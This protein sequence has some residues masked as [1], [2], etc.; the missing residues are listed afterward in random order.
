MVAAPFVSVFDY[1]SVRRAIDAALT[2]DDLSD[3]LIGDPIYLHGAAEDVLAVDPLAATRSGEDET[4]IKRA[5]I[6]FLAAR[7]APVVARVKQERYTDFAVQYDMIDV[8]E[9]ARQLRAEALAVLDGLASVERPVMRHFALARG[10][11]GG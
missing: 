1:P 2:A 11:R 10:R 7:I 6:L 4:R 9:R 8:N 3:D 5:A